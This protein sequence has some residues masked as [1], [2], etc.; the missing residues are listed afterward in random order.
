MSENAVEY[1][2]DQD[3]PRLDLVPPGI[4][5]AVG[6]I[7]TYGIKKYKDPENWR[8]VEPER[9]TA[10]LMRH[11][12]KFLRDPHGKDKESGLPHLW[13]MACNIAFLIELYGGVKDD[14]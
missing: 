2:C 9:Y 5:E 11:L 13:H 6:V 12:C 3:K 4:I 14:G 8:N 10:A 1:K 7:R